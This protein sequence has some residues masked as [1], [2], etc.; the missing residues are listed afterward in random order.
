MGRKARTEI[1]RP[2]GGRLCGKELNGYVVHMLMVPRSS[3]KEASSA[4]LFLDIQVHLSR[5]R[6]RFILTRGQR[7]RK[8]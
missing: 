7:Y 2:M 5:L 8:A 4:C 3:L 1:T 6:K